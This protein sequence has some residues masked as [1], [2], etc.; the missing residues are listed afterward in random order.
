MH[1]V[2]LLGVEA[3]CLTFCLGSE[4][5]ILELVMFLKATQWNNA[6]SD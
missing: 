1:P 4:V 6:M 3:L 2:L 5:F